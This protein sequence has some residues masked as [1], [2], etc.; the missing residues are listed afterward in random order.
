MEAAPDLAGPADVEDQHLFVELEARLVLLEALHVAEPVGVEI[1]E[2]GREGL[3]DLAP[4]DAFGESDIGVRCT[5][6][7]M[8][9]T[10]EGDADSTLKS[11]HAT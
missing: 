3:L 2:Q 4:R 6:C 9:K 1:F 5:S 7:R 11:R 8:A 10:S